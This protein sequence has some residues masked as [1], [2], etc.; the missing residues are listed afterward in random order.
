MQSCQETV[1]PAWA[2]LSLNQGATYED[3]SIT[4]ADADDSEDNTYTVSIECK[5]ADPD[6]ISVTPATGTF[7][8]HVYEIRATFFDQH[9]YIDGFPYSFSVVGAY[10]L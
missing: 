7:D 1:T 3:W 2:K 9:A 4:F 8:V 10:S 5:L 6:W